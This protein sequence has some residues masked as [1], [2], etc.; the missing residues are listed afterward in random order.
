MD[1]ESQNTK[2][3]GR[4][5]AKKARMKQLEIYQIWEKGDANAQSDASSEVC[6][7]NLRKPGGKKKVDFLVQDRLRDAV[8]RCDWR[9]GKEDIDIMSMSTTIEDLLWVQHVI[10]FQLQLASYKY[11]RQMLAHC[12]SCYCFLTDNCFTTS[13]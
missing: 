12:I 2:E 13:T 7:R 4:A 10:M 9:E 1:L 8:T 11:N 6:G 3:E 5:R